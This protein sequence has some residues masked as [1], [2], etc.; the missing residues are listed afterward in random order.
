M[1]QIDEK[2]LQKKIYQLIF[3]DLEKLNNKIDI[4]YHKL[5][6]VEEKLKCLEEKE[7]KDNFDEFE[8]ADM[9]NDEK[10]LEEL[11]ANDTHKCIHCGEEFNEDDLDRC[12]EDWICRECEF[13]LGNLE[14]EKQ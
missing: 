13:K 4:F 7:M 8:L 11:E 2:A 9:Q 1:I 12:D 14:N 3:K 10:K 5:Y 6:T